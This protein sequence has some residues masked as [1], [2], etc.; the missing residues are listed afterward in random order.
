MRDTV[1]PKM[2]ALQILGVLLSSG[3]PLYDRDNDNGK[4]SFI[5]LFRV[6]QFI[7]FFTNCIRSDV[8]KF[9]FLETLLGT[10]TY[11]LKEVYCAA[12]EV[13]N[14]FIMTTTTLNIVCVCVFFSFPN[15]LW[16]WH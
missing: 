13:T 5:V 15:R 9:K 11:P 6:I 2:T 1:L 7:D 12:A 3:Y 16:V 4:K 10:L 14:L 8:P